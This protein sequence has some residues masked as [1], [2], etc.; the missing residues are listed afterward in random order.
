MEFQNSPLQG[1]WA[2]L[3]SP[4]QLWP[5]EVSSGL[6]SSFLDTYPYPKPQE[7]PGGERVNN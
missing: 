3:H 6:A 7:Q 1:R 5:L 2:A 4:M